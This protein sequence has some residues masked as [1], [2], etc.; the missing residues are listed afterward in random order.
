MMV[1]EA[2]A[3]EQFEVNRAGETFERFIV[4][5]IAGAPHTA[6]DPDLAQRV[7]VFNALEIPPRSEFIMRP[8]DATRVSTA[9]ATAAMLRLP[10]CSVDMAPSGEIKLAGD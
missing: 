10:T 8:C 1:L 9:L 3:R 4:P 6:P 2:R 5:G 7:E